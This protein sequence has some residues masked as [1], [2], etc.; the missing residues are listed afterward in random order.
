[1]AGGPAHIVDILATCLDIAGAE[2]PETFE[3]R[4]VPATA[5]VSLVPLLEGGD[6]DSGRTLFWEHFNHRAVRQGPWK[7]VAAREAPWE[8]YELD[9]DPT[10]LDDLAG[11]RLEEARRLREVYERWAEEVGVVSP[12]ELEAHR[13]EPK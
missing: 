10:E 6:Y 7:L 11:S 1:V 5:G 8:L 9:T 3:G 13:L 2:Y 4:E 12:A